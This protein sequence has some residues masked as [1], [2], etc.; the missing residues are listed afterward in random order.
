M[1]SRSLVDCS[2]QSETLSHQ[3]EGLV[4]DKEIICVVSPSDKE[5]TTSGK[6]ISSK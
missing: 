3:M 1:V 2:L 6:I 4:A 5:I